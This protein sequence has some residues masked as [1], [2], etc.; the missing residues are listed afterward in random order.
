MSNN[1]QISNLDANQIPRYTYDE[2]NRAVRVT[3]MGTDIKMPEIDATQIKMDFSPLL[4]KMDQLISKQDVVAP[5]NTVQIIEIPTFIKEIE[6]KEIEKPIFITEVKIIEIEKPVYIT[7]TKYIEKPIIV[8]KFK[9]IPNFAKVC[10]IIQTLAV[11]GLLIVK[12]IK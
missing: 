4:E 8:E 3:I 6:I 2:A 12:I 1:T 5:T 11:F 7:E 10:F 9:E